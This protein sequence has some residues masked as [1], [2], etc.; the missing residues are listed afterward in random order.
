MGGLRIFNT[1]ATPAANA[2]IYP[3]KC[4]YQSKSLGSKLPRDLSAYRFARPSPETVCQYEVC[5]K[6][7]SRTFSVLKALLRAIF[8]GFAAQASA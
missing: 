3:R 1:G 7:T 6:M 5:P 4:I 2:L 8:T